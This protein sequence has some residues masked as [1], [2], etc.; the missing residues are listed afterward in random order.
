MPVDGQALRVTI[1]FP[2]PCVSVARLVS[3]DIEIAQ[4]LGGSSKNDRL[5]RQQRAR[6]AH[7]RPRQRRGG[8]SEGPGEDVELIL[9]RAA[10]ERDRLR[11]RPGEVQRVVAAGAVEEDRIEARRWQTKASSRPA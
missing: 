10:V 5:C 4:V 7:R 9:T 11:D 1:T 2:P 8:E 3:V 6:P